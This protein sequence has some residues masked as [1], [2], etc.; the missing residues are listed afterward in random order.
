MN[1]MYYVLCIMYHYL[2]HY[3]IILHTHLHNIHTRI[4]ISHIQLWSPD[5]SP[6]GTRIGPR[7]PRRARRQ[8]GG[9]PVFIA[10]SIISSSITASTIIIT[11]SIMLLTQILV[12]LSLV[13]LLWLLL[14]SLLLLTLFVL[15]LF[16]CTQLPPVVHRE[17][18]KGGLG[19]GGLLTRHLSM[20]THLDQA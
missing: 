1:I 15:Q 4:Q 10:F 12:L 11:T 3:L 13:L 8:R 17:D 2:N 6:P 18:P 7:W 14:L 9:S 5:P 19:K 20:V 16:L